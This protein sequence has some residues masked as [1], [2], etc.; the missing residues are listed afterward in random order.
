[1]IKNINL[2]Q[3]EHDF[4]WDQYSE[5]YIIQA[6]AN[7]GQRIGI[8][9][10]S[11]AYRSFTFNDIL[12]SDISYSPNTHIGYIEYIRNNENIID[13]IESSRYKANFGIT[14]KTN[15]SNIIIL[16]LH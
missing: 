1:M 15:L 13:E 2:M 5:E 9:G 14:E 7:L 16:I 3:N 11:I 10:D 6:L 4:A 8:K 12:T